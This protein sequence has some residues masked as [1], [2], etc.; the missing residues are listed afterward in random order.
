MIRVYDAH[1]HLDR[2]N[3]EDKKTADGEQIL[4]RMA[5]AG[6]YGG[7]VIS[8]R[9]EGFWGNVNDGHT[10]LENVLSACE[11][12]RDRLFPVLWI[13]PDQK[14]LN[15]LIR[16]A[17]ECGIVAF[18]C[19]CNNFYIYEDKGI[20]MLEAVAKTGKPILFHSGILWD[21]SPS[22]Q[23]NRPLNWE[24]LCTIPNLRFVL[25]HCSWPWTDECIALFGKFL[26]NHLKHPELNN[27]MYI[28]LT[29]GTPVSYR[30]DL[31]TKL[32]HCGYDV[33]HNILWGTDNRAY[34]YN[35]AWAR[36]WLNIDNALMD[37]LFIDEETRELIFHKNIKRLYRL[38]HYE[39]YIPLSPT[40]DG[41][42]LKASRQ[43]EEEKKK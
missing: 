35:G 10:Q 32:L 5:E 29:P 37:E 43:N 3:Y 36:K 12:Y 39:E 23:Y 42:Q 16:E 20:K 22:A 4:S 26:A 21:D 24:P 1:I 13:H 41:Q 34:D 2:P 17:D 33:E 31:L 8:E 38:P 40:S 15:D 19:I 9:P 30:R 7:S 18:K 25:A 27:E 11:G 28:D 6:I 14:D